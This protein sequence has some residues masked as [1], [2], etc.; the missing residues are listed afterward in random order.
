MYIRFTKHAEE[1]FEILKK[2]GISLT[3]DRIIAI[4]EAPDLYDRSRYP[5]IIARG[6]FDKSHVMRIV[7]R[8]EGQAY[9]IITF[10][11]GRKLHYD[12]KN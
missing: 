8:R 11:P 5:L 3:H 9:I 4:L 6:D 7:Y 1:K 12:K 2:H 10:Y